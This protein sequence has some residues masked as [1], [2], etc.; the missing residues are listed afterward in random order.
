MCVKIELVGL[1]GAG[2]STFIRALEDRLVCSSKIALAYPIVPTASRTL[3]YFIKTLVYGF[4]IEPVNFSQFLL[5][6]SNWWLLKKIAYRHASIGLREK[7][8]LILVDSGILQ[9]FLSFEIEEKITNSETPLHSL[10]NGVP[11]PF[12]VVF[13]SVP[14]SKAKE[15]YEQRGVLGEG[16]LIRENSG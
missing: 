6:A 13:F 5:K 7:E 9:L 10:L 4:L 3:T 14:P 1:C 15:R 11:L 12:A 8:N 16:R 2:K